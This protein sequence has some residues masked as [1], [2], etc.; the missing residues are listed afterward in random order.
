MVLMQFD[1]RSGAATLLFTCLP[2]RDRSM[3]IVHLNAIAIDQRNQNMFAVAGSDEYTRLYDIRKYKRDGSSSYFGQPVDYFCPP[4]LIRNDFYGISGLAFS[5]QS[6]LL[7]TYIEEL[8]Y[9]FT[10]DMGLGSDPTFTS[11]EVVSSH[12]D[13]HENEI[14][15][16]A[17]DDIDYYNNFSSPSDHYI[18]ARNNI[19]GPLQVYMG[20]KNCETLK[21]V[22]FLGPNSE[23]VVSGSDCGRIFIWN[24][25]SGKLIRVMEADKHVV[26][27]IDSHP[28]TPALA[29][30]GI[31]TDIKIWTPKATDTATLPTNISNNQKVYIYL[32]ICFI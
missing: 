7:V 6:E 28:H 21:N 8:I 15:A 30:S 26:N 14:I 29:S 12:T 32:Y 23:Y 3:Q 9:L 16:A 17:H 1:L 11:L 25:K 22:N 19:V 2:A 20:H 27:C 4:H 24:K 18:N 10:K 13:H 31:E 5:E